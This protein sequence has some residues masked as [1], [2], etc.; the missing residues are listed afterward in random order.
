MPSTED[1][2]QFVADQLS[3]A[4]DIRYK[5]MF[6]EYCLYLNEKVL[7]FIC[8][9]K[10]LIKPT[11]SGR[12]YIGDPVLAKAYPGSKDYFLIE[13]RLDDQDWLL[14]LCAACWDELPAPKPKKAKKKK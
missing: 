13:D 12:A 2:T 1:F 4:G 7:A 9:D 14:G 10:L 3:P 6:G 8:D 5:K 11:A